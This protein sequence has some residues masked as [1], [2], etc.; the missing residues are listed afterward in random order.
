MVPQNPFYVSFECKSS[1][2]CRSNAYFTPIDTTYGHKVCEP[3][4]CGHTAKVYLRP[5]FES[6]MTRLVVENRHK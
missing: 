4:Y 3:W 6:Y 2:T 5:M 1:D